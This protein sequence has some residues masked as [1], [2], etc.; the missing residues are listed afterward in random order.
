MTRLEVLRLADVGGR[1]RR[2]SGRHGVPADTR[3]RGHEAER[4][5]RNLQWHS[6]QGPASAIPAAAPVSGSEVR[7]RTRCATTPAPPR[8]RGGVQHQSAR[9][10]VVPC[11]SL[12]NPEADARNHAEAPPVCLP[13][14]P[15]RWWS[16]AGSHRSSGG[17]RLP[18]H[19]EVGFSSA[20][21]RK[22]R[23]GPGFLGAGRRSATHP[24]RSPGPAVSAAPAA[25]AA[26]GPGAPAARRRR[27][28]LRA[29]RAART[30]GG[31]RSAR[32]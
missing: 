19:V 14:R 5:D 11:G 2:P 24:P 8:K 29:G 22:P 4:A 1:R 15:S 21:A 26:P 9:P 28:W 31:C 18:R 25:S 17:G 10:R 13:T 20:H 3:T 27:G 30:D 12:G 7:A 16:S 32:G 23:G 6:C